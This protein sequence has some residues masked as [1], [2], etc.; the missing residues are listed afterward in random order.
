MKLLA[1]AVVAVVGVATSTAPA[2]PVAANDLRASARQLTM[3]Q[4]GYYANHGTYT[5]DIAALGLWK[6]GSAPAGKIW[7]RVLHAGGRSWIGDVHAQ[8]Q[9]SASCVVFVGELTDF[10]SVPMTASRKL[11]P[12]EE[13]EPVCDE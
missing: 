8:G 1:L 6:P 3:A 7:Y 12:V 11:K 10:P 9:S 5:T 4:E 13:G 2:S